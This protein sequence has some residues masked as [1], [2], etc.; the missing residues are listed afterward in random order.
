MSGFIKR[1]EKLLGEAVNESLLEVNEAVIYSA[2][3]WSRVEH[4][5]QY[6]S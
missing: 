5:R 6:K 1:E 4:S 3:P 2:G